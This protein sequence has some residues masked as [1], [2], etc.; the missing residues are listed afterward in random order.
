MS[1]RSMTPVVAAALVCG[2]ALASPAFAQAPQPP[3][4]T[5]VVPDGGSFAV[6]GRVQAI[7][8]AAR[9]M[10]ITSERSG[11]LPMVVPA[12]VS[13]EGVS[14]G[15]HVSVHYSR[16]VTF[17]VGTPSAATPGGTQT[18]GQVARTPGGIGPE[19]LLV[20]G[21]V[22]RVDGPGL[23]EIVDAGGGGIYIVRSTDASRVAALSAV[24]VGDSL[25]VSIGPLT[26]TALARCNLFGLIC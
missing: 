12:N 17:V 8:A 3:T 19:P 14:A 16:T 26:V 9:T 2:L 20:V 6:T 24:K 21:R 22:T 7:D 18:V 15:D 10:T 4:M 5:N 23:L 13:L 1:K 25:T 11:A